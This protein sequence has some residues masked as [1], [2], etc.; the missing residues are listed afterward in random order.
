MYLGF[1]KKSKTILKSFT[2]N[3]KNPHLGNDVIHQRAKFELEI[4]NIMGYTKMKNSD[5]F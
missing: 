1:L 4:P 2:T 3:L 5:K